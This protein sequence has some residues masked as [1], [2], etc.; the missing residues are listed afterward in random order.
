MPHTS[1]ELGVAP[2]TTV[3]VQQGEDLSVN[4]EALPGGHLEVTGRSGMR[5]K[6]SY[7]F[8]GQPAGL[9]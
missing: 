3:V 2:G 5:G 1:D 7:R 9:T 8:A 4:V 6:F